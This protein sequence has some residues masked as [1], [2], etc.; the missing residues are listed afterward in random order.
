MAT[1]SSTISP[2]VA[3]SEVSTKDLGDTSGFL[4]EGVPASGN[5]I[6]ILRTDATTTGTWNVKVITRV[7]F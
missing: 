5:T 4:F 3:I 7:I 1:F 6:F 2:Y